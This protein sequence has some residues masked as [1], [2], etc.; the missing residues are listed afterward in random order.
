MIIPL[1]LA[2]AYSKSPILLQ[3]VSQYECDLPIGYSEIPATKATYNLPIKDP[4]DYFCMMSNFNSTDDGFCNGIFDLDDPLDMYILPNQ[5]ISALS[6]F[7]QN[8]SFERVDKV[9]V[10]VYHYTQES[11]SGKLEVLCR[12]SKLKPYK[13]KCSNSYQNGIPVEEWIM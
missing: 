3:T 1:V 6:S 11:I 7:N 10:Y 8:F 13:M 12:N 5:S 2:T 4:N 9:G